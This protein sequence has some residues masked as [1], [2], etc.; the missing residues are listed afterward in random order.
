MTASIESGVGSLVAFSNNRFNWGCEM[1]DTSEF[2]MTSA[3]DIIE[4]VA[5]KLA[6]DA[7]RS[8]DAAVMQRLSVRGVSVDDILQLVKDGRLERTIINGTGDE[9]YSLDGE[10]IFTH[11][12]RRE[13]SNGGNE[14]TLT[15]YYR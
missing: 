6:I 5:N 9:I 2:E 13:I 11:Y 14:V 8:I 1:G 10:V 7:R 12:G 3:R 15:S 4:D